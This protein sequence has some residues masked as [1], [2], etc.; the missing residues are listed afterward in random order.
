MS[1]SFCPVDSVREKKKDK[2]NQSSKTILS[3]IINLKEGRFEFIVS[4]YLPTL[5]KE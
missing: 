3:F 2:D 4:T 1:Q 5:L